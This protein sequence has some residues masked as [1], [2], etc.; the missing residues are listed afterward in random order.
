MK[1]LLIFVL[2]L[3]SFSGITIFGADVNYN[4]NIT[5]NFKWNLETGAIESDL[6]FA[7][8]SKMIIGNA[9]IE[10]LSQTY[11]HVVFWNNKNQYIGYKNTQYSILENAY[12]LGDIENGNLGFTA[13]ANAHF[14]S[15][16]MYKSGN[17]IPDANLNN[18]TLSQIFGTYSTNNLHTKDNNELDG[19]DLDDLYNTQLESKNLFNNITASQGFRFSGT[20]SASIIPSGASFVSDYISIDPNENYFFS[21]NNNGGTLRIIFFDNTQTYIHGLSLTAT[22]FSLN[23][24]AYP[25]TAFIRF[26][27]NPLDNLQTIQ[28]E[29]GSTATDYELHENYLTRDYFKDYEQIPS[30]NYTELDN[31]RLRYVVNQDTIANE[32]QPL[33]EL[34]GL[35]LNDLFDNNNFLTFSTGQT[36]RVTNIQYTN[37]SVSFENTVFG[38]T[39]LGITPTLPSTSADYYVRYQV[40]G[41]IG[42]KYRHAYGNAYYETNT[43]TEQDQEFSFKETNRVKG[44]RD[45]FEIWTLDSTT[46]NTTTIS[47]FYVLN[48]TDLGISNLSKDKLDDYYEIYAYFRDGGSDPQTFTYDSPIYYDITYRLDEQFNELDITAQQFIDFQ[49]GYNRIINNEQAN[50]FIIYYAVQH[51]QDNNPTLSFTTEQ[52]E[53]YYYNYLLFEDANT[54]YIEE[55]NYYSLNDVFDTNNLLTNGDFENTPYPTH[56][57]YFSSVNKTLGFARL[58]HTTDTFS[59]TGFEIDTGQSF[60]NGNTYYY[61][62][63]YR[64]NHND[65]NYIYVDLTTTAGRPTQDRQFIYYNNTNWNN[66]SHIH[67][68]TASNMFIIDFRLQHNSLTTETVDIDNIWIIDLTALGIANLNTSQ[69][70]DYYNDYINNQTLEQNLYLSALETGSFSLIQP[71]YDYTAPAPDDFLD[72]S[73]DDFLG[74]ILTDIGFDNDLG[75]SVL[76]IVILFFTAFTLFKYNMPNSVIIGVTVL[77]YVGLTFLGWLPAWINIVIAMIFI[78]LMYLRFKG[79]GGSGNEENI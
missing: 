1:K 28:L 54:P 63:D 24:N 20:T 52:W 41:I 58:G 53:Q 14:F 60:V 19:Y 79:S 2:M 46:I 33:H 9:N 75:K 6:K 47:N 62:F 34:N 11:H 70:D 27:T 25:S 36:Y 49:D 74:N 61:T 67:N 29:K 5:D 50:D 59:F 42:H 16:M 22:T 8:T 13:P 4:F 23:F 68:M 71:Y 65:Y 10:T 66:F 38:V 3:F 37:N 77:T 43:L 21:G 31:G 48:L 64:F 40:N 69:M 35:S 72:V 7:I 76:A 55:L 15:F 18:Q 32:F 56:H 26:S 45:Y 12:Y 17:R 51:A 73:P 39:F 44:N 78:L 57:S 30:V